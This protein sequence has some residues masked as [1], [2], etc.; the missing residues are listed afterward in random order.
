MLHPTFVDSYYKLASHHPYGAYSCEVPQ[1]LLENVCTSVL[2]QCLARTHED[3]FKCS[4]VYVNVH[5]S[6]LLYKVG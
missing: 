2:D 3:K 4:S 1:R 5:N 6:V